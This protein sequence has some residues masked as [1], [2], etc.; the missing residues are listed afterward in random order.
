MKPIEKVK[1][2]NPIS[3]EICPCRFSS[4][5]RSKDQELIRATIH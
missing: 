5:M 3:S 2:E 1:E 4:I